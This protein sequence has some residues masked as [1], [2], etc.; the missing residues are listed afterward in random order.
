MSL[1][2]EKLHKLVNTLPVYSAKDIGKS[3]IPDD[4]VYFIMENG[5]YYKDSNR[6]VRIG[7]NKKKGNL[8]NKIH[9]VLW[10]N[11]SFRKYL[12]SAIKKKFKNLKNDDEVNDA[13]NEYIRKNI[14]IAFLKIRSSG[15]RKRIAGRALK[16]LETAKYYE[17]SPEWLGK[18]SSKLYVRKK[19]FWHLK[20]FK[21]LK[22]RKLEEI[23]LEFLSK[24]IKK[25]DNC[26]R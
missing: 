17:P 22:N 23:D 8:H 11:S 10:D 6:I 5:E 9:K 20:N 3:D 12:K 16:S 1:E 7:F 21:S 26:S 4:G 24:R 14:K 18:N 19:G 15:V 13:L 25:L 2:C